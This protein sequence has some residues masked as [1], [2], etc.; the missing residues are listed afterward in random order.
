[1]DFTTANQ[2]LSLA[3]LP[4]GS[5]FETF[6]P[7]LAIG[8]KVNYHTNFASLSSEDY[9]P[10]EDPIRGILSRK[11]KPI[12]TASLPTPDSLLTQGAGFVPTNGDVNVL[13]D[14]YRG[15][16]DEDEEMKSISPGQLAEYE[17]K[18]PTKKKTTLPGHNLRTKIFKQLQS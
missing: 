7:F 15:Q 3:M 6:T 8:G 13:V 4:W 11:R 10:T 9:H 2:V 12:R 18:H 14:G 17:A 16:K 1:M 5:N